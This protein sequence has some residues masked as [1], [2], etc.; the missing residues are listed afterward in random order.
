MLEEAVGIIRLMWRE[1]EHSYRGKYFKVENAR[2]FTLPD[3]PP[4][5]MIAASGKASAELAGRIGDGF[6]STV[7]DEKLVKAFRASD[8]AYKPCYGQTAVCWAD[9]EERA[10]KSAHEWWPIS[11]M[12][13]KLM[14]ELAT[15][16]EFGAVAEL[17]TEDAVA[18]K[19]VCGP[20][21]ERH[22]A[23]IKKYVQAGFDHIYIHQVGPDQEG[24]LRF[25]EREVLP[26]VQGER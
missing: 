12:P 26:K 23:N 4:P 6:I 16:A 5:I 24:F 1:G 19:I 10:R 21:P 8:N 20:D 17:V 25:Y 7:P 11:A 22:I 15:P 18:E 9:T 14:T 3:K 2:V 13:G